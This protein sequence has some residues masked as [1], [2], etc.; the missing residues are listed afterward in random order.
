MAALNGHVGP[1]DRAVTAAQER[2]GSIKNHSPEENQSF[3]MD[4]EEFTKTLDAD[5]RDAGRRISSVK[6]SGGGK[7]KKGG[8]QLPA[9]ADADESS[10]A[11]ED[12]DDDD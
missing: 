6:G 1:L 11:P 4:Y 8:K 5:V 3:V 7:G 2:L 10:A 9:A 12:D